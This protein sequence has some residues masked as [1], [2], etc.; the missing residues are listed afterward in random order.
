MASWGDINSVL[1]R[2][3]RE[4]VITGFSTNLSRRS[5]PVALHVVATAPVVTDLGAAEYDPGAIEAIRTRILGE[6]QRYDEAPT[7]TIE[8]AAAS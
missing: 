5:E 6:L 7:V 2:L 8:G 1:N 3:V 4:G